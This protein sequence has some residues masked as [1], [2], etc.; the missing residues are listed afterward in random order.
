MNSDTRDNVSKSPYAIGEEIPLVGSAKPR[1]HRF[2]SRQNVTALT[3]LFITCSTIY[4]GLL[5]IMGPGTAIH[6]QISHYW[7]QYSPFFS[8][9]EQSEISPATP[10]ECTVT[11]VQ[12]L[13]R[14]GARYPT[15]GKSEVYVELVDRIQQTATEY[16]GGVYAA[17][18]TYH[19]QLGDD[20]LTVFGEQQMT[21]SGMAFYRRYK[22]LARYHVPF[23]RASGSSRVI[24][25]GELFT[26]GF[27]EAKR[28]D[29]GSNSSQQ[30]SKV[31]LVIPEGSQW[32]NT[33]DSGS[34]ESLSDGSP[35]REAEQE[36]LN[37]FA[38]SILERL[39]SNMPGVNLT[40]EDVPLLMDLCP[41][42][43]VAQKDTSKGQ[44][45]PLC[46]LFTPS[47]WKSYDYL[48]TL[49]KYYAYGAGNP[50]AS[51]RG[52]G[53]VNEIIARMTKT[54][55]VNDHT[56]VNHTLDSDPTTFPLDT[57]LYADFSHDNA[58][59]SI[60]DA[61]GL[62]NSTAK[63]STTHV[64]SAAETRGFSSSWVVP[65]ASR[66]YFELM[67]CSPDDDNEEEEQ[68]VRVLIND[69]VVPLH[70]CH[71]DALGR[72]K[73]NDWIE[74]LDFARNGGRWDDYC[75]SSGLA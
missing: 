38:P 14:H 50:L 47:E 52:V 27:N 49:R 15:A 66:A 31:N 75:L 70:G 36:F 56:S 21:D 5:I 71:V 12:A 41:F 48:N 17:L 13:S 18:E 19:Y 25:S 72:C 34:C 8:L 35:V 57:T 23:I 7:G 33:L 61:F 64:Q 20:E 3:S 40:L 68:L 60:F 43:V 74:G 53:Y 29:R 69:R 65:F 4:M 22:Q 46:D 55:P 45:S 42:E 62:Y 2:L 54:L 11:F 44:L 63:L 51:T 26:E 32:N 1:P 16:K 28:I 24:A 59:V 39:V 37:V 9:E 10:P 30:A 58:M 73:L 67:Q 6:P